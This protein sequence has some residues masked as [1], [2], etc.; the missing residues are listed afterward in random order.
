MSAQPIPRRFI[1]LDAE[2]LN[3]WVKG[4]AA[5]LEDTTRV[6]GLCGF[7]K[8]LCGNTRSVNAVQLRCWTELVEQELIGVESEPEDLDGLFRQLTPRESTRQHRQRRK[9]F[10]W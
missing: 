3:G 10:I 8:S 6:L 1:D 4:I 9:G 2:R 5:A 7:L